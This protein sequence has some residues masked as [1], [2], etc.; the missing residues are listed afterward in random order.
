MATKTLPQPAPSRRTAPTRKYT[1]N[2]SPEFD[3]ILACCSDDP[4]GSLSERLEYILQGTDLDWDR[5]LALTQQHGV[6]PLLYR[7]LSAVTGVTHCPGL[8]ALGQQDKVNAHRTL[9]LT[10]ELLN[11]YKHLAARGS[12]GPA[13]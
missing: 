12:R 5:L 1:A 11:I 8:V 3:L 2:F 4:H 10:V 6:V 7:R 9:R 13:L